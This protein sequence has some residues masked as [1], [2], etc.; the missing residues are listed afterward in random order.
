MKVIMLARQIL[1]ASG[2]PIN[3]RKPLSPLPTAQDQ[4]RWHQFVGPPKLIE[5]C[6]RKLKK[7]DDTDLIEFFIRTNKNMREEFFLRASSSEVIRR[8]RQKL[9]RGVSASPL[10][11][12]I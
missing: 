6:N 3:Q 9:P 12:V 2:V 1:E 5:L 10:C 11:T 8:Y 4:L 7:G